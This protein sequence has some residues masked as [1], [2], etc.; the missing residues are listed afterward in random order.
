MEGNIKPHAEKILRNV[1]YKYI[2][3]EEASIAARTM[4]VAELLGLYVPTDYILPLCTTH[5]NDTESRS[6]PRFVSSCLTALSAVIVHSSIN[7]GNQ[8]EA[9]MDKLIALIISSDYL[10]SE[11]LEVM[12][13][14]LRVTKNMVHAAG[15][16]FCKPRRKQ[17][18]KILLQLGS[19]PAMSHARAEVD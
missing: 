11:N 12:D 16:Q 4:K 15:N 1:I 9:H 3:D 17:L 10:E 7:F 2:L 19:T 6:V 18:F 8:F 13:R 14:V 5:L